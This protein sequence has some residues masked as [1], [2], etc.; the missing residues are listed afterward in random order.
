MT[1]NLR[2]ALFMVLAMA[3][4]ALEDMALKAAARDIP[5]GQAVL[6][7]GVAG[8]LVFAGLA[9]AQGAPVF[10][11]AFLGKVLIIRSGFEISG[12]LFYALAIAL[13]PLSS[14]SAI[15]QATPL[16]VA[17]GAVFVF[18]EQVGWR[19]WMAIFAGFVGVLMILQ[20]GLDSFDP[21]S[22]FAVLGMIG[23]AGRD[24][25][26]RASPVSMSSAQLGVAGFIVLTMAGGTLLAFS[27]GFTAPSAAS[28]AFV[29]LAT[30]VGV[31]AYSALTRAMR[32]GEVSVVTP[33]RYSR[34][35]FA[36]VLGIAVFGERPDQWTLIGGMVIV[37]SGLF[38]LARS[39]P[40]A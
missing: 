24:L 17:L 16:V 27:G 11:P 30:I 8:T 28:L 9:K 40:A 26:T 3:A 5:I 4:F 15:L 38:L 21:L 18:G 23:F 10:H 31:F 25:A 12:R 19:R 37:S 36:L 2:G 29:A 7:F 6:M 33:F 32:T 13:T 39:R 1:D 14:A 22:I 35:L 34:L 20:P